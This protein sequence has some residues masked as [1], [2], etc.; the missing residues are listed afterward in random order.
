MWSPG[1]IPSLSVIIPVYNQRASVGA[2][3]RSVLRQ[4]HQDGSD[5][6]I[7]IDD[8]STDGGLESLV[9]ER[10]RLVR[11]KNRG[12][13]AA[14]NLG[15]SLAINGFVAFL[16]ADDVWLDGARAAIGEMT[17]SYPAAPLF[18]FKSSEGSELR[19]PSG[20]LSGEHAGNT[21]LS[22]AEFAQIYAKD[23]V[24]NSSS[25]CVRRD[26]LITVGGFPLGEKSGEDI[27]TW[28]RLASTG[29][30][31]LGS[32]AI[33]QIAT[34]DFA[35]RT[36]RTGIPAHYRALWSSAFRAQ[37]SWI[38]ARAYANFLATRLPAVCFGAAM[39][40]RRFDGLRT[41]LLLLTRYPFHALF[42][43]AVAMT[44]RYILK[45]GLRFQLGS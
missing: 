19:N 33:S 6:L 45:L 38:E 24:L 21:L 23:D 4:L 42:G 17:S 15:V 31:V 13:A 44:P 29:S 32:F 12:V 10:L 14:R 39:D 7:V 16:D 3:V 20:F 43:M 36:N 26:A 34:R 25:V 41:S 40:R 28:F 5:E 37:L 11:T 35:H 27:I 18:G 1:N 30:V 2:A 9:D 22:F 8:G